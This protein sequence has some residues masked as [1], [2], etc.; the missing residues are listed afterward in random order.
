MDLEENISKERRIRLPK[1]GQLLLNRPLSTLESE[2]FIPRV[3]LGNKKEGYF[4]LV[5]APDLPDK[6]IEE[7][8]S[9]RDPPHTILGDIV[10][11]NGVYV[12]KNI[13]QSL[14]DGDKDPMSLALRRGK[15]GLISC[16]SKMITGYEA[17][18]G[19]E[20]SMVFAA[21][22]DPRIFSPDIGKFKRTGE[23]VLANSLGILKD[24]LYRQRARENE[25]LRKWATLDDRSGLCNDRIFRL[26]LESCLKKVK[27]NKHRQDLILVDVDLF[28]KINDSHGHLVGDLVISRIGNYLKNLTDYI[29]QTKTGLYLASNPAFGTGDFIGRK[30]YGANSYRIGGDEFAVLFGVNSEEISL[31]ELRNYTIYQ[32]EKIRKEVKTIINDQLKLKTSLSLGVMEAHPGLSDGKQWFKEADEVLY[33]AKRGE[34]RTWGY[35]YKNKGD[36]VIYKGKNFSYQTPA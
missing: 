18:L 28:K 12:N 33:S 35:G 1:T 16:Y 6:L 19:R 13:P 32:T 29:N 15:T 26:D 3:Y 25:Q 8:I 9:F 4:D 36:K 10:N 24:G 23:V 34:K 7:G 2:L 14:I 31:N 5:A 11:Y 17:D 27:E 30:K 20:L 21:N 22:F